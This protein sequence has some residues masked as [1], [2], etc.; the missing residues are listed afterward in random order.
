M[1]HID[2]SSFPKTFLNNVTLLVNNIRYHNDT[3]RYL[4]Q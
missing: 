1:F 4:L 3:A 2:V